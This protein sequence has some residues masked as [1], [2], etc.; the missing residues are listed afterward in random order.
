LTIQ[1]HLPPAQARRLLRDAG[2]P[3]VWVVAAFVACAPILALASIATGAS[4]LILVIASLAV[5]AVPSI[6][7]RD[8]WR[9]RIGMAWLAA[10]QRRRLQTPLKMP[11]TPAGAERWL[12]QPAASD[13]GL[14]QASVL[15]IAGRTAEARRL[16]ESHPVENPEDRARVAR[17]LAAIDGLEQGRVDPTAAN[18]AIDALPTEAR[19]YHRMSLAWSTAWVEGAN[20]R[21]WRRAFAEASEGIGA[22][23]I[24]VRYLAYGAFQELLAPFVGLFLVLILLMAGWL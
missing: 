15:L 17:L 4:R 16:V 22:A 2:P 13:A 12:E 20:K 18:A 5:L 3:T 1:R 7:D 23:G 14:T 24:P 10:E 11:R 8:G 19:R 21:V 6:L 9:I